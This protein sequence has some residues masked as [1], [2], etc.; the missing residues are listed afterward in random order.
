MY[1]R[2]KFLVWQLVPVAVCG[3]SVAHIRGIGF[4]TGSTTPLY[5]VDGLPQDGIDYLKSQSGY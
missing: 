4:I 2:V 3:W 1:F 5:I